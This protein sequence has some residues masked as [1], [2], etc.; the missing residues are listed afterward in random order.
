MET[1]KSSMQTVH[2]YNETQ[3]P[4]KIYHDEQKNNIGG[5]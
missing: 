5:D 3:E 1:T 4:E 2:G